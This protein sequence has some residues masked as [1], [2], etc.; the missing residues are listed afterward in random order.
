MSVQQQIQDLREK[1]RQYDHHYYVMSDPL[2]SDKDYDDLMKTLEKLEQDNPELITLDSPTQRVSGGVSEGF[3]TVAHRVPMLSLE[4]TYE[5]DEITKWEE[6][7]KRHLG[8]DEDIEYIVELKMDGVSGSV[9]YKNGSLKTGAT[10]GDGTT[11]EDVT[12]NIRT[13]KEIPLKLLAKAIPEEI[14]IRGEIFM[15]KQ[16]FN[17]LNKSRVKDDQQSFA[18]ARN[19]TSGSLKLLDTNEVLKRPLRFYAHSFGYAEGIGFNTHSDFLEF[20]RSSGVPVNQFTKSFSSIEEVSNYCYKVQEETREKLNYDIDGMVIKVND[21]RLREELG[22]TMKS[23]RWAV[24]Y[25][26]PAMQATT[27]VNDV[28]FGVGRTGAITPRA[29]LE[30]VECGGVTISHATLHNF[31]EVKRLDIRIGDTVL[32]E[33]AG[34][35]IPKVVKVIVEERKEGSKSI[36]VPEVCP[37]CGSKIEKLK[38]EDVVYYCINS[39]CPGQLRRSLEHFA[40]KKAMDIDGLGESVVEELVN[41]DAVKMISD[42]YS[43]DLMQISRLPLFKEKKTQNLYDALEKSKSQSLARFL[44]GLGIKH[45]G[46]KASKVLAEKY[47]NI[48]RFFELDIE[49]LLMIDDIGDVIAESVVNFFDSNTTKETIGE[50]KA[51][52][53]S[54]KQTKTLQESSVFEG[55]KFVLTGELIDIT[56][57]QA[58]N[59]IESNGGVVVSSVSSKTDYVLVGTNPG[60]KLVKAR[61]LGV[62]VID[63]D[64]F[65]DLLKK[66]R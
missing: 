3:T 18:N 41:T 63:K 9:I 56:R 52:G 4:N 38:E 65:S 26:F 40:S 6:K 25:K 27:V 17:L 32:I 54:L 44:F 64:E 48:D 28:D 35:V 21:Y 59:I 36:Q 16:S 29:I 23:P 58:K 66:E 15:D 46:E 24:A 61:Q 2:V 45:V 49:E 8:R 43:L 42:I 60:S 13:I 22:A 11:G 33:R 14:E 53:L 37:A 10:R 20:C 5:L 1:I 57:S 34:D 7:I 62:V 55:K 31:D 47:E 51:A 19:A 39:L 30:P 50:F 12:A